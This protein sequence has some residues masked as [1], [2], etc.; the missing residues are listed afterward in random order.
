MWFVLRILSAQSYLE[1]KSKKE[2]LAHD[3]FL[4]ENDI[5]K[6][7][8][9]NK[10]NATNLNKYPVKAALWFEDQTKDYTDYLNKTSNDIIN[11]VGPAIAVI[12]LLLRG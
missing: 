3:Q 10:E 12:L 9:L 2:G 7:A 11:S 5:I 8:T 6:T 4:K 1:T